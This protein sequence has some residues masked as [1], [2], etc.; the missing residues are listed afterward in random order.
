MEGQPKPK[1]EVPFGPHASPQSISNRIG[2]MMTIRKVVVEVPLSVAMTYRCTKD[3]ANL[4][5]KPIKFGTAS[6]SSPNK[7]VA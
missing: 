3:R 6:R 2:K 7:L 1:L 5:S 4:F